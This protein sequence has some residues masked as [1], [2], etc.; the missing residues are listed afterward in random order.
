MSEQKTNR[1]FTIVILFLLGTTLFNT[2]RANKVGFET[3]NF[4]K[5]AT[6][7]LKIVRAELAAQ[8]EINSQLMKRIEVL[9]SWHEAEP[10]E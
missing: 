9:E 10:A 3:T 7:Q 5:E 4:R 8:Q 6:Y 2:I 1:L